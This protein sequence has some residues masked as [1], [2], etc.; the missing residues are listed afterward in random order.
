MLG[1]RLPREHIGVR[2][3]VWQEKTYAKTGHLEDRT[4]FD[5]AEEK[6]FD[7]CSKGRVTS[8]INVSPPK[9]LTP[10]RVQR[11]MKKESSDSSFSSH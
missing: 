2:R 7:R 5:V 3:M 10:R 11:I 8:G 1:K 4:L 9:N 6:P